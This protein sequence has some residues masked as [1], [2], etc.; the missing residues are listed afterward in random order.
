MIKRAAEPAD[1]EFGPAVLGERIRYLFEV[2][3]RPDGKKHS[4][5]EV[6]AGIEKAGGP[7][8]SIGYLSLLY[9]GHKDNPSLDALRAMAS[10]FEVPLSYFDVNEVSEE[11]ARRLKLAE[12]LKDAGVEN[13]AMR[14][15]GLKPESLDVVLSMIDRMRQIEGLPPADELSADI[16]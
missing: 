6:I 9:R 1:E 13:V 12:T 5:R 4:Y 10:F 11:T 7:S 16:E 3:R 15:V 2:K 8:L 14:S